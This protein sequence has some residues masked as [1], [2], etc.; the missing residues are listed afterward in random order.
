MSD[1]HPTL[2]AVHPDWGG[3]P[4]QLCVLYLACE[5]RPAKWLAEALAADR[6]VAVTIAET[7]SAA[8]A[9]ARL[10]DQV[11]DA[12]ILNHAPPQIDALEVC[13]GL[14][15]GGCE[16]P[17]VV[18]G[19][20]AEH[21]LTPLALEARAD[22]YLNA[23]SATTRQLLWI[24]ARAV[25]R[26]SLVREN[27]RLAQAER[28]RQNHERQEAERLLA[29]QRDMLANL[30]HD[31]PAPTAGSFPPAIKDDYRQLVRAHVMMGTGH[32]AV[33]MRTLAKALGD[34]G[35]SAPAALGLHVDVLEE[36]IRG[37]GNRSARHV[38]TRANLLAVEL[39]LHLA[40]SYRLREPQAATKPRKRK[41]ARTP[42][43]TGRGPG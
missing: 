12:I 31:A 33:E 13:A 28:A 39:A 6:A 1:Q 22:Q 11:F 36:L 9:A 40:E 5:D 34:A 19:T 15:A 18:L 21:D 42:S 30:P 43:P 32:L 10:R 8:D 24:L 27:R 7:T 3:L 26:C 4:A 17:I 23:D 14:R 25:E 20:A 16:E 29:E 37:L 35:V 41:T 38:T 2:A